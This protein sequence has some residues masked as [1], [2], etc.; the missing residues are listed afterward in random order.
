MYYSVKPG[1]AYVPSAAL[2]IGI[3]GLPY[4]DF[5]SRA[6]G[7]GEENGMN[8]EESKPT[9]ID[10]LDQGKWLYDLLGGVRQD[11]AKQPSTAVIDRIR[12]RLQDEMDVRSAKAAA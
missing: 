11:V 2:I 6:D 9:R 4:V 8:S 5:R 10:K 7:S 3:R 12:A 1:T